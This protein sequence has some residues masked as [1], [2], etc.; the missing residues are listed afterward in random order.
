MTRTVLPHE[1]FRADFD[2]MLEEGA[3]QERIHLANQGEEAVV[4]G[5]HSYFDGV[6]IPLIKEDDWVYAAALDFVEEYAQD[7][8]DYLEMDGEMA[9]ELQKKLLSRKREVEDFLV[10]A[11]K[12]KALRKHK[13]DYADQMIPKASDF[14]KYV[15][16]YCLS[17]EMKSDAMTLYKRARREETKQLKWTLR[18]IR[19][20]YEKTLPRIM[21]VTRRAIRVNQQL[22]M[23]PSY[24]DL[25]NI[26]ASISWLERYIQEDHPLH[27]VLGDIRNF[28][29]IARNTESHQYELEWDE[30][31]N[32]VVLVDGEEKLPVDLYVF[33]QR[34][35]YLVYLCDIGLRG[36]L[37]AFTERERG[38]RSLEILRAYSKTFPED[39]PPGE[40]AVVIPYKTSEDQGFHYLD[41]KSKALKS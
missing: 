40:A 27:P 28:Y 29:R 8:F 30:D 26:S 7:C 17:P 23:K 33:Q 21:Y 10:K 15:K 24:N 19:A 6:V 12:V 31:S 38:P 22:P 1:V 11:F 9:W 20:A 35:R 13:L 5:M 39:F 32:K 4:C 16:L 36:I 14:I 25:P 3:R 34:Y 37:A 41:S 18:M 2:Q